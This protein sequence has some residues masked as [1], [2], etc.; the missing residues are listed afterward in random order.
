M[1]VIT[2]ITT[3]KNN[4][5]RYNVFL[6]YGQ[7]EQYAFSVDANVLIQH[8][9]RKGKELDEFDMTEIQFADDMKKAYNL[10]VSYLAYR[11]RSTK[12]VGDYLRKKEMDDVIIQQVLLKLTDQRY[13]ND[14]EFAKAYVLTQMNTTVKGPTVIRKELA[15]KGVQEQE[16]TLSLC[17][18]P[19]EQQL[20][21]A[22]K[23][24]EKLKS[25]Y[26]KLSET[27][28]KQ[29]IEQTLLAKGHVLS[30]IQLA[31]EEVHVEKESDEEWEAL[32]YQGMKAHRR[33]ERY[34]GWEYEKRMKQSLYRKG[35]SME[36]IAAFLDSIRDED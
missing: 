36:Q 17:E 21:T 30:V 23:V 35:F 16:I 25:K 31:F 26:K 28:M 24:I 20:Q 14:V 18:Y 13:L 29:K 1:A 7:G 11:M 32:Q 19:K 33:Y 2:K 27:M 6:D 9:L 22:M 12:E 5:E 4:A 15:E 8:D 10:A 34:D 3:Q